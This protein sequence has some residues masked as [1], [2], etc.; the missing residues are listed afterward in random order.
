MPV[1]VATLPKF[2]NNSQ[3]AKCGRRRPIRVHYDPGTGVRGCRHDRRWSPLSSALP[4]WAPMDRAISRK[5]VTMTP[6]FFVGV[7]LAV[8]VNLAAQ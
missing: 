1:A 2:S 8:V 6:A 3:C 4:V 7:A 5:E